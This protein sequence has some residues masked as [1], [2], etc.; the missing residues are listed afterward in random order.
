HNGSPASYSVTM[1][2]SGRLQRRHPGRCPVGAK[3]VSSLTVA[4]DTHVLPVLV[5][6]AQHQPRRP[7]LVLVVFD[8]VVARYAGRET[9]GPVDD[10]PGSA[11]LAQL[12]PARRPAATPTV[13][14]GGAKAVAQL[15]APGRELELAIEVAP[16]PGHDPGSLLGDGPQ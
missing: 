6:G 16:G 9:V 11:A 14:P 7:G 2:T 4:S 1:A 12:V 3:S 8:V 10:R 15:A 13:D 5:A